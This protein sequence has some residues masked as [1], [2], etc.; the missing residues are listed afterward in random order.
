LGAVVDAEF[1]QYRAA[2]YDTAIDIGNN[3]GLQNGSDAVEGNGNYASETGSTTGYDEDTIAGFGGDNNTAVDDASYTANESYVIAGNGNDNYASVLGP[4]NSTASTSGDSNIAYVV[5][6]FGSTTSDA[7]SGDGITS[8]D[9]A[10]VLF[11]DG[12]ATANTAD[13]A[14]DIV[15][16]SGSEAGTAAATSGGW[17]AE[18]LSLF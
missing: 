5:D 8:S 10:A 13:Y 11:T 3:S 9:L 14:Y 6:P 7:T 4:E 18:L 17:L 2:N 16:A 15:T 1:R 12:T